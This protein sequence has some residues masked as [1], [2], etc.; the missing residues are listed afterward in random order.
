MVVIES[1]RKHNDTGYLPAGV[2]RRRFAVAQPP[3]EATAPPYY[4]HQEQPSRTRKGSVG[5][6]FIVRAENRRG[7]LF[8]GVYRYKKRIYL[9]NYKTVCSGRKVFVG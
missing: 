7:F 1:A 8:S 4:L 3:R 5:Y 9:D 2:P 6:F